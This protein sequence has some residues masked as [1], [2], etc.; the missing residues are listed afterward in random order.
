MTDDMTM[1]GFVLGT[2]GYLA[3][4]RRSGHP[5]TVQS[6]LYAVGAVMVEALTGQRLASGPAPMERSRRRCRT[7]PGAPWPRT[8]GNASPRRTRWPSRCGHWPAARVRRNG[9]RAATPGH[10]DRSGRRLAASS[11]RRPG[12][13]LLTAPRPS[14]RGT[15]RQDGDAG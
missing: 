5:A 6:D 3:P 9:S 1:T 7:S 4:E 10:D 15:R 2:P 12:T 11:R 8:R 13:A 14:S